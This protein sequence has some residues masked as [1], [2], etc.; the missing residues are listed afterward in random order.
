MIATASVVARPHRADRPIRAG[1]IARTAD[2]R[3]RQENVRLAADHSIGATAWARCRRAARRPFISQRPRPPPPPRRRVRR[4]R[5]RPG[6]PVDRSS[7]DLRDLDD[8]PGAPR[9]EASGKCHCGCAGPVE[10]TLTPTTRVR[11]ARPLSS[12]PGSITTWC[13]SWPTPTS[14]SRR[15]RGGCG[16]PP[17]RRGVRRCPASTSRLPVPPRPPPARP[18]RGRLPTVRVPHGDGGAR[19]GRRGGAWVAHPGRERVPRLRQA[20]TIADHP[21]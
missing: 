10:P 5:A 12:Q 7:L 11:S 21:R 17:R 6:A 15:M 1:V 18:R 16:R 13:R 4:R 8:E 2:V 19:R 3:G 9:R 20:R 14:A